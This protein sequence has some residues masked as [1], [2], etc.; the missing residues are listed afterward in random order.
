MLKNKGEGEVVPQKSVYVVYGCHLNSYFSI[1]D[2][3]YKP[4]YDEKSKAEE[5][6][7]AKKAYEAVLTV[8]ASSSLNSPEYEEFSKAVKKLSKSKFNYTYNGPVNNFVGNFHDAVRFKN[9][10]HSKTLTHTVW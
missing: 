1:D 5:N 7:K 6:E 4:W 10:L 8:T 2:G 3:N 9:D